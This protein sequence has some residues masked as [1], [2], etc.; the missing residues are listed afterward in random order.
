MAGPFECPQCK[1][2]FYG[3]Q[4]PYCG[5]FSDQSQ[6]QQV[7]PEQ[8][9]DAPYAQSSVEDRST[10][11]QRCPSCGSSNVKVKSSGK[12]KCKDCKDR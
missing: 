3:S 8:K 11:N 9:V 1:N 2:F 5:S 12:L 10:M 7:T 6:F 4:C